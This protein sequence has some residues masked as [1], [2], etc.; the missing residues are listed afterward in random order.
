M[1]AWMMAGLACGFLALFSL[2]PRAFGASD[3]PD[4]EFGG[5]L[6]EMRSAVAL[7]ADLRAQADRSGDKIRETCAYERLR[8]MMQAVDSTQ[9]AQVA[10]E[11]AKARGDEAGAAAEVARAQQ[12]LDLVRRMRNEADQ[13]VGG[14]ELTRVAGN[15][16]TSVTVE[17]N[18]ADDDPNAGPVEAWAVPPPRLELSAG[19][20]VAASIF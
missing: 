3:K 1:R 9:I 13:C 12:A 15:T 16:A 20:P 18:V 7:T 10:W 2:G 6:S 4:S 19:L 8:G 17:T 5:I 14:R 11:G